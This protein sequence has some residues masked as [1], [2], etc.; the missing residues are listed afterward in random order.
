MTPIFSIA[1]AA[2]FMAAL[3]LILAG[4]LVLANKRLAVFEDPRIDQVEDLL[5]HANCGACGTA[6]CRQFAEKL[7]AG[8]VEPG[9]CTVNAKGMNQLNIR[10]SRP[11]APRPWYPAAARAAPGAALG[12]GTARWCAT[13][14]P[15]R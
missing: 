13:S 11:A 2:G 6:G 5:P 12:W 1:L 4:V 15:F 10:G 8:E 3:G 7:V 9:Q 14:M